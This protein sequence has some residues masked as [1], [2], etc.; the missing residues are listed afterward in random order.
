M[1]WK[2]LSLF[3]CEYFLYIYAYKYVYEVYVRIYKQNYV[4]LGLSVDEGLLAALGEMDPD[5]PPKAASKRCAHLEHSL[6][7]NSCDIYSLFFLFEDKNV[8]VF[9]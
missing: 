9:Q 6:D 2:Q 1:N 8:S 4:Y 3:I 5:D 7:W